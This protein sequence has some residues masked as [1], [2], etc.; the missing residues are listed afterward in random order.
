MTASSIESTVQGMQ[1]FVVEDEA[2][3]AML[4]EDMLAELGCILVGSAGSVGQALSKI[5]EGPAIDVAILDVN[6]GGETVFPVAEALRARRVPF[7][8]S[9]GFG[10]CDLTERYPGAFLLTKPYPPEALAAML[11]RFSAPSVAH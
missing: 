8:F 9:T 5:A 1:V 11:A 2:M 4:L 3:L 7:V 6:L 10:S